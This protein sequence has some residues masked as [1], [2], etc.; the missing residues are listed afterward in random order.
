[1]KALG[2][3]FVVLVACTQESAP[4]TTPAPQMAP[5]TYVTQPVQ[6]APAPPKKNQPARM[7]LELGHFTDGTIGVV[8]D[9]T[10][11]T[12]NIADIDPIKVRFDGETK[13]WKLEGQ[14]GAYGRIDFVREGGRVMVHMFAD[15]QFSIYVP[16][17]DG[18]RSSDEIQLYRDADAD[19]L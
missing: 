1:M 11:K 4:Q 3:G 18:G 9:R 12:E 10:E 5:V 17:P 15:N 16:D 2:I 7:K 14:H 19:P 8:I 13:I 6:Q